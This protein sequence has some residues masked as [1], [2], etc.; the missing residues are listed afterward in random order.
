[1]SSSKIW[2]LYQESSWC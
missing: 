1:M 2:C